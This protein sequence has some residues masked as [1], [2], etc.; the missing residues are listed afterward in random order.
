MNEMGHYC[1][2]RGVEVRAF[3]GHNQG[4]YMAI[5]TALSALLGH[6]PPNYMAIA[7]AIFSP[8]HNHSSS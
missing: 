3:L 2:C 8:R 4:N 6:R 1:T 7:T 5:A